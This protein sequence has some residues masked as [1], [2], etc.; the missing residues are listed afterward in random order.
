VLEIPPADEG[1]IVG[2][3]MDCWQIPLEDVGPAGADQ[4]NGGRYVILPPGS[5]EPTSADFIVL[6]SQNYAGYALLRAVPAAGSEQDVANA[7]EYLK[8]I[9]S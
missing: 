5:G 3:I 9:K 1:T 8:R 7:A 2:S 6:A 4:G